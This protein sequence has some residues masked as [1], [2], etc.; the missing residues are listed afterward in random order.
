MAY[1]YLVMLLI[2]FE[3]LIFGY[4][5]S[6]ARARYRVMAPAVTGHPQFERYHRVQQNTIEQLVVVLPVLWVFGLTLSGPWAAVLGLVFVV[7]RA[8]Y[9]HGYITSKSGGGRHHGFMLGL[10]V[11][12]ALF[13]GAGIGAI[14]AL[15]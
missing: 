7:A 5:V 12:A 3:Y 9:A 10:Y 1:V 13:I 6:R 14:K 11:T 8:W 15:F 2:L 4:L